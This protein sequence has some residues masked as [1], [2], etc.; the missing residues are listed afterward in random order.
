MGEEGGEAGL[1]AAAAVVGEDPGRGIVDVAAFPGFVGHPEICDHLPL[2]GVVLFKKI[3]V[4][5]GLFRKGLGM[6]V[7]FA[8][9]G[10]LFVRVL[11]FGVLFQVIHHGVAHRV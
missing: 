11:G 5:E 2:A 1:N 8:A 3:P 6:V 7:F 4:Q 9:F 10:K